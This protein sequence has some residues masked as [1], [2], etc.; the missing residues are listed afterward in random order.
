MS[1]ERIDDELPES[2]RRLRIQTVSARKLY[3]IRDGRNAWWGTWVTRWYENSFFFNW[4]SARGYA[5]D[6]RVQGSVFH[7]LEVPALMLMVSKGFALVTQ[8]GTEKTLAE[9]QPPTSLEQLKRRFDSSPYREWSRNESPSC[10]QRQLR[11][12]PL[13]RQ[14]H[15]SRQLGSVMDTFHDDSLFW[16]PL[17]SERTIV[18][19]LGT[20]DDGTPAAV[21]RKQV[22]RSWRSSS[23]GGEY[24]LA[25][26]EEQRA[27]DPA[28]ILRIVERA[29][30]WAKAHVGETKNQGTV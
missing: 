7:I 22:M 29:K 17:G 25:W 30:R 1:L 5:E 2:W 23:Y 10:M 12:D 9:Y 11:G 16:Q 6:H 19:L 13:S 21:R 24:P 28:S 27:L 26:N 20:P 8:L 15:Q 4:E 18:R 3:Y 14:P